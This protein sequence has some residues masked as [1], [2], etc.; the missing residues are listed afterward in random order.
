MSKRREIEVRLTEQNIGVALVPGDVIADAEELGQVVSA[1]M[2]VQGQYAVVYFMGGDAYKETF[3]VP[4]TLR[5]LREV[6]APEYEWR[7]RPLGTHGLVEISKVGGGRV[8]RRYQ[9]RWNVRATQK[10][11]VVYEGGGVTSGTP[12]THAEMARIVWSSVD[13]TYDSEVD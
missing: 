5:V 11:R 3:G 7:G 13:E 1:R 6:D 4:Q 2:T 10:G 8:G 9:G 12:K